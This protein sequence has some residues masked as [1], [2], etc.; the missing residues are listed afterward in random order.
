MTSGTGQDFSLPAARLNAGHTVR[1]LALELDMDYRTVARLEE[2]K[3]VHPAKAKKVADYFGIRV[4]DL[5]AAELD[6]KATA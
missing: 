2:G 5:M 1:T 6:S 3:P 4:T